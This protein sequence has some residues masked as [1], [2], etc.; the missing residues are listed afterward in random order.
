MMTWIHSVLFINTVSITVRNKCRSVPKCKNKTVLH[1]R[2]IS[3][4]VTPS[5]TFGTL[6]PPTTSKIETTLTFIISQTS[7]RAS[8]Y[9]TA[10]VSFTT[11]QVLNIYWSQLHSTQSGDKTVRTPKPQS[12]AELQNMNGFRH[13]N[14]TRRYWIDLMTPVRASRFVIQVDR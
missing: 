2:I 7:M 11:W 13:Q 4:Y 8:I 9:V 10:L 5:R 1:S 6:P 14:I 12:R 3:V